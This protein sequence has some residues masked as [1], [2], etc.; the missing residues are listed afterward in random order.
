MSWSG[1]L[2][3]ALVS[4]GPDKARQ[5]A[6]HECI[7]DILGLGWSGAGFW[8]VH[9]WTQHM[10]FACTVFQR[11]SCD[12]GASQCISKLPGRHWSSGT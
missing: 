6:G 3:W 9:S 7:L 11:Q 10:K 5:E 2:G 1:L 4:A 8:P 12:D